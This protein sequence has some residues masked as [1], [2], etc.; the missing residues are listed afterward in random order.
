MNEACLVCTEAHN[1]T[2]GRYC[3]KVGRYVEYYQSK[4]C[5]EEK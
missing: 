1:G 5:L 3:G 4:P 2:N